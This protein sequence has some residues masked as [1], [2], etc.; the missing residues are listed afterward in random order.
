VG[1]E[2]DAQCFSPID[3]T[4]ETLQNTPSAFRHKVSSERELFTHSPVIPKAGTASTPN[5][6]EDD[7]VAFNL[8]CR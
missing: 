7:D 8:D 1:G 6:K 3:A 5:S 2:N 4:T